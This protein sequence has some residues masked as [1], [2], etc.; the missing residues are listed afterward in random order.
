VTRLERPD[1]G[2]I[3]VGDVD[4]ASLGNRDLLRFRTEIQMVFQD[5]V[6]SIN[7]RFSAKEIIEEPAVCRVAH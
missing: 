1:A 7:P 2:E 4:I 5:A 6:T 3:R